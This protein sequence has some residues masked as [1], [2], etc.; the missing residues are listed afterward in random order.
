[1]I[2]HFSWSQSIFPSGYTCTGAGSVTLVVSPS[3]NI[4]SY[5]WRNTATNTVVGTTASIT[6]GSGSYNVTII[7]SG[8]TSTLSTYPV[9]TN[10]VPVTPTI[11]PSSV[12]GTLLCGATQTLTSSTA[13]NYTW[14][15][16]GTSIAGANSSTYS[17]AGNSVATAGSYSFTVS[18]T[19]A[20]SGC[21]ATSSAVNI[22]L[23]PKPTTPTISPSSVTTPICGTATQTLTTT[24]VSGATYIWKR[25][26]GSL[27]GSTNSILVTGNDVINEGTYNYTVAIQ[28]S[29]GCVSDDSNPVP[30]KV[31]PK[32]ATPT[33]SPS[34]FTPNIICGTDFK[35]LTATSGGSKYNWRRDG[36]L[37][38]SSTTTNTLDVKGTDVGAP[39]GT[40]VYT[41]A[42]EN[43]I[44]CASDYSTTGVTLQL[45]P[46]VPAK[47]T[48]TASGATTFCQGGSVTL[49]SSYNTTSNVWSRSF[50]ADTTTLTTT[51]L[52]VRNVGVNTITV[53]AKDINGCTSVA[54]NP[55]VVTVN[56]LPTKPVI[57]GG[58]TSGSV[59]ELDSI[60]L[61][62]DNKGT[63]TYSWSTGQNTSS[64]TIRG[65]E[66]ANNPTT[67]VYSL[68][69]RDPITTCTSL[70]SD[71]FIL[72]TNPLPAKPTITPNRDPNFCFKEFVNLTAASTTV[73]TTFE[74]STGERSRQID[75]AGS[76]PRRTVDEIRVITVRSI[77]REGCKS[78]TAS[79]NFTVTIFPLPET[80]TISANGP[81]TFC[82]DSTVTLTSTDSPNRVYK[83]I[84]AK[85]GTEFSTAKSVT[86]DKSGKYYV[87]TISL[88]GC[89]SDTSENKV[90]T[91]RE[92]PQAAVISPSPVT[93]TVCK[94]G[95]VTL[96]AL[97]ANLNV[98]K[99]S[100]RDDKTGKEVSTDK[101]ITVDTAGTF[102]V[103][104]R[105]SFGCFANNYSRPVSVK[106][107]ALPDKPS[108]SI[109][110][111]KI[112]CDE[113]ST[114][115]QSSLPT[116]T[117]SGTKN[118][119]RWIVDGTT[120][121]EST[122]RTF[123]W[124]QAS[125]IAVA[126]TD[127]NGCKATIISDTIRT[128]VNPLPNSPTITVRGAIP[129]C[130][131]KN[132]TLNAIGTTGVTYRW[133]TGATTTSITINTAGTV[134]VQS[135]NGF[136]CFSKPSQGVQVRVNPLPTTPRLTANGE[137]TFC[138][139]SRVRIVSSSPFK[140][141]WWRSTTDSL[142][143]GEDLT[144]I[145]ASKTG[146]YFAKVQDDNGCISL[147]S[148]PIAVDARP[149]PTPTIIKQVGTFSLDAQGVG[150]E[151]GYIWR[152][153][154]DIQR[155]LTTRIIKAKR[156]GDYRVQASIIYTN[157]PATI[158]RLVC[159]SNISEVLKYT[160]DLSFEGMS[161]FP[162]PSYDG[163]IN[164]EVIEDLIGANITIY[165]LYGRLIA[166]YQVDKFNTLKRIQLPD[167]H[168]NTY[169]VRVSTDGY[170]KLKK[171][172]T[173]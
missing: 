168:G 45:F 115:V 110:K 95:K 47:P 54:S 109:V 2:S 167:Y 4:T 100:W 27:T 85:D 133:S 17:V 76:L 26:G 141:F 171:I 63:G 51:G 172:I 119:Y 108:I 16:N 158:G 71:V 64:I 31:S 20:V 93:A 107:N 88:K 59:C 99:Y 89:L 140:A 154:G 134:T 41:V 127:T 90:I 131:D 78:K 101:E 19:N 97:F 68:T 114:I 139:G 77:S 162:N 38:T 73:G 40:Y 126:V 124:K 111:S 157:V 23:Q 166:D 153:N 56:A 122:S 80:P 18:T 22:T 87:R 143:N 81:L 94:G 130:A 151:N 86:I 65:V 161:V 39:G 155:D 48:I 75:V 32:P 11:I 55:F 128:T 15:R 84:N 169:V 29:A 61:S 164:V 28:T 37:V 3:S 79:D 72:T 150:D 152:Y 165:D 117:P 91:V 50:A 8:I 156:D 146:N 46:V 10:I 57:N 35:T 113:D 67:A 33:I 103:K 159:F 36:I 132:V 24:A 62:S 21:I 66:N 106:I 98:T 69:Y 121:I 116:T 160:Q 137:T 30:L 12:S 43:S 142:G 92:A 49:N 70:P 13:A 135:I 138:D 25:D 14:N 82:P 170:E 118:L 129:F 52:V 34:S 5:T 96:L 105:D 144:S 83:W 104:V 44:G 163:V 125:S 120:I 60:R 7:R 148:S 149:N 112:F 58:A 145:F 173:F 102:S 123:S 9:P 1:M 147:P 136:G 6:V 74:W 53:R 42:L